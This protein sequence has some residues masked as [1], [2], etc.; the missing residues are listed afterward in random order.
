[1]TP[2]AQ[3]GQS[4]SSFS[5][6]LFFSILVSTPISQSLLSPS[7]SLSRVLKLWVCTT[8]RLGRSL[9]DAFT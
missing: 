9:S 1:M 6:L 8:M 5:L 3:E 7:F 2:L 4:V